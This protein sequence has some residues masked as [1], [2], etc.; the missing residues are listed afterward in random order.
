M[1]K[2]SGFKAIYFSGTLLG[3]NTQINI[4]FLGCGELLTTAFFNKDVKVDFLGLFNLLFTKTALLKFANTD[5][6]I[7]VTPHLLWSSTNHVCMLPIQYGIFSLHL[8]ITSP[9][10]NNGI[11]WFKRSWGSNFF[12]NA[13]LHRHKIE[14]CSSKKE[15]I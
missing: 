13:D 11:L 1:I 15:L 6:D 2:G 12:P 8:S 7:I 3:T 9:V 14:F 10:L 4:L 5:T